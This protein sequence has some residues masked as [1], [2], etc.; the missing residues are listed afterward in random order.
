[1][2]TTLLA[3]AYAL[4]PAAR[5]AGAIPAFTENFCNAGNRLAITLRDANPSLGLSGDQ[6]ENSHSLGLQTL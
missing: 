2:P 5:K 1:M 3:C 6:F 4:I